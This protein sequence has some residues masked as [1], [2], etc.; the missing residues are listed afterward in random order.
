MKSG[1][2]ALATDYS[3]LAEDLASQGF[4]VVG[5]D[6]PYSTFVVVFPDGRVAKRTPA[7]NPQEDLP[8][9]ARRRVASEAVK[10]WSADTRFELDPLERLNSTDSSGKFYGPLDL[11]SVGVF[12]PLLWRRD[13]GAGLSRRCPVQGRDR[14][15]RQSFR[16]RHRGRTDS[17]FYLLIE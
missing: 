8:E 14:H 7:G 3:T 15:G 12:W 16:Q 5:S 9:Q 11:G 4:M 13:G 1:I 6:S 2:G 17:A 10:V